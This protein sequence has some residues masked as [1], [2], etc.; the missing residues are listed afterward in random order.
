MSQVKY[1]STYVPVDE[2]EVKKE[3]LRSTN[4]TSASKTAIII[5]AITIPAMAIMGAVII[6]MIV[7]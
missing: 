3:T 7:R 2:P 1:R 4:S 5:S 6:M